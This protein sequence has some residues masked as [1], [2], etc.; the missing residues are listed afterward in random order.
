ME[1]PFRPYFEL[2]QQLELRLQQLKQNVTDLQVAI[3][4]SKVKYSVTL[5]NLEVISE[6]IHESRRDK[7]LLM[8]PRQPG[9]GAERDS[10]SSTMS[11][12]NLG[13]YLFFQIVI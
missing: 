12:L 7:I 4:T 8:F 11:E 3:K 2:K 13:T 1:I 9:V 10:I 6:E 5:K